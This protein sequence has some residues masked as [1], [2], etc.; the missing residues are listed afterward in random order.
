M[1][2]KRLLLKNIPNSSLECKNHT[3]F[4]T[5]TAKKAIPFGAAQTYIA[6]TRSTPWSK[7]ALQI[8]SLAPYAN[9]TNKMCE[10][11]CYNRLILKEWNK[12]NFWMKVN[13]PSFDVAF[14][15]F[16]LHFNPISADLDDLPSTEFPL[17]STW[18]YYLL[19]WIAWSFHF[20]KI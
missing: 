5:K 13:L 9:E 17:L 15:V 11:L 16:Y 8:M 3:L 18:T 20:S 19:V 7:N 14:P 4:Q 10:V 2:K 12:V 6:Y 1:M